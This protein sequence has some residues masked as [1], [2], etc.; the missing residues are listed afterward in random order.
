MMNLCIL[1]L[2]IVSCLSSTTF[3]LSQQNKYGNTSIL[4]TP[5][6]K[7]TQIDLFFSSDSKISCDAMGPS[8]SSVNPEKSTLK[9]L[10]I[11]GNDLILT[12]QKAAPLSPTFIIVNNLGLAPD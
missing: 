1:S 3:D 9:F 4:N 12:L 11:N 10:D 7:D 6:N 5:C 8:C 2:L